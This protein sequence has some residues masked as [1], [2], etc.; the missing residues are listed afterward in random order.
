M[1]QPIDDAMELSI[2]EGRQ[3]GLEQRV[4]REGDVKA[5]FVRL[6]PGQYPGLRDQLRGGSYVRD[7]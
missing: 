1:S 3:R 2:I 5:R 7:V 4:Q 6:D